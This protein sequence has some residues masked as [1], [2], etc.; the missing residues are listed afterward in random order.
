MPKNC[1]N[2]SVGVI[3]QNPEGEVAL[4]RRA[5]FP[6]GMAPV[7]GHVDE[8]GSPEQAAIDEAA[9]EVGLHISLSGLRS[10]II[11]AR[12]QATKPPPRSRHET[13]NQRSFCR[14]GND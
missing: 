13:H 10:T 12:L 5:K 9:E 14:H 1:D 8:H 6:V 3:I 7:A 2:K 11:Q 4:L